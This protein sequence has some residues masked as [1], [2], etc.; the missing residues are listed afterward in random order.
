MAN[1]RLGNCLLAWGYTSCIPSQRTTWVTQD[2]LCHSLI[3]SV[4][5]T[6]ATTERAFSF[7]ASLATGGHTKGEG[8]SHPLC[9]EYS[10]CPNSLQ[11]MKDQ[12]VAESECHT[13][14]HISIWFVQKTFNEY[15]AAVIMTCLCLWFLD[16]KLTLWKNS[17][18]CLCF[19]FCDFCMGD[20][21][22]IIVSY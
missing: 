12:P 3:F 18:L 11:A 21:L 1:E 10:M 20:M 15:I 22:Y 17:S 19:V 5:Q 2:L 14:Y 8:C 16:A 13:C 9:G 7:L 4:C 6:C